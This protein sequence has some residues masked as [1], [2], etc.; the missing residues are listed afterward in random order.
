[1]SQESS[2]LREEPSTESSS[3]QGRRKFLSGVAALAAWSIALP[4][5]DTFASPVAR[6]APTV[7]GKR[8]RTIDIHTHTCFDVRDIVAGTPL[9]HLGDI[10][11]PSGLMRVDE[12]RVADMD[13]LGIDTQ[14][15]GINPFWYSA[16][17]DLVTRIID[18]QNA[19]LAEC[20]QRYPGRFL[21]LASVA[22]QFP[23]LAIAQLEE[24]M[25]RYGMRGAFIG[26]FVGRKELSASDFDPF[27]E[28]AQELGAVIMMHPETS[29][30]GQENAAKVTGVAERMEGNGNLPNIIG[31]PLETTIALSHLIFSGMLDRFPRLRL[32]AVHGGGYIVAYPGRSDLACGSGFPR[33]QGPTLKRNPS[34]YLGNL[35]YDD[36]VFTSEGLRHLIAVA[37]I[38]HVMMGSDYPYPW[39]TSPV[40]FVLQAAE[41][42]DSDRVAILG[43]NARA[44]LGIV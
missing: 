35:Y 3:L 36:M 29:M 28:K 10:N 39:V 2:F 27:W 26:E 20:C 18:R 25:H 21:A 13:R 38:D 15:L 37:G 4:M 14:V 6:R 34:A 40:D 44:F 43:G 1:M 32:C 12:A 31:D 5:M 22:L 42:N 19:Q 9:E 33:C 30:I 41:L 23:D 17:R 7:L 24:G 11:V 8:V 16:E